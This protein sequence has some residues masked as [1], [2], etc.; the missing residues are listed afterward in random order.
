VFRRLDRSAA[1]FFATSLGDGSGCRTDALCPTP[2]Q[3]CSEQGC[4]IIFQVALDRDFLSFLYSPARELGARSPHLC[5]L[6]FHLLSLPCLPVAAPSKADLTPP[7]AS[8][9]R[10]A[11]AGV[12]GSNP[13][14]T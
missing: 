1:R 12:A 14:V 13:I 4:G 6:P 10:F 9:C 8:Q 3:S 5:G 2:D 11:H 7:E